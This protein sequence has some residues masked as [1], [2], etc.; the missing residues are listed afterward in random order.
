MRERGK[1]EEWPWVAVFKTR[2]EAPLIQR[3]SGSRCGGAMVEMVTAVV[4]AVAAA[5]MDI[6]IVPTAEIRG[7]T[8]F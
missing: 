3:K 6:V 8:L 4:V 5:A 7:S 2:R 1:G